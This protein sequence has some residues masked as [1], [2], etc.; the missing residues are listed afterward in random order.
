[1]NRLLERQVKKIFV[2][3]DKIPQEVMS[4]IT[5]IS[6]TY[7]GFDQD[8]ALIERS[9]ELSSK[10]LMSVNEKLRNETETQKAILSDLRKAT[11]I[12]RPQTDTAKEWLTSRDEVMYLA[13]SLSQLVSEQKRHEEELVISKAR[14][15]QEKSKTEAILKSIGDG[16][17]AV[18]LQA[19]IILMNSIAEALSGYSFIEAQGKHYKEIFHFVREKDLEKDYPAFVE[20]VISTGAVK[21]LENHTL[22]I[23]KDKVRTPISDSAAPIKN[24]QGQISGCIVVVRDA[25]HERALEQAKDDFVSIAAHQLRTPL[26]S[27]R[28][29]L[30]MIMRDKD[31]PD[32]G[33]EKILSIY[34]SNRRMAS[35]V[36]DLLNV[37]RID[38]GRVSDVPELTDIVEV[39][40][41]EI[42]DIEAASLESKVLIQL[43]T[44]S[45]VFPK[46]LIDQKRL[47]EIIENLLS[48]A[49]KYNKTGG[50]VTVSIVRVGDYIEMSIADNGIGIPLKD[51][52]RVFSKFYRAENAARSNTTGSGLGLFV[53]KSFVEG[54]GGTINFKSIEGEGTTFYVKLPLEIKYLEKEKIE[55]SGVHAEGVATLTSIE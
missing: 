13:N 55:D 54:W 49:I 3:V 43:Q 17:F 31:L 16:V 6:D 45:D 46:I 35:L 23:R 36:N 26:G 12:L 11:A 25:T 7:D 15:E 2:S 10:E 27:M 20:E 1:M 19:R 34:N 42:A 51:Q 37:S 39:I 47:C 4:L 21:K 28:W 41:S 52:P 32:K 48:N 5:L 44:S 30:E 22:L 18:D 38:Q 40:K 9:L 50:K 29:N 14:A 33:K 53:V 24:D 8:R